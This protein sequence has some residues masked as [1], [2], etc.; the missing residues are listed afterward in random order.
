MKRVHSVLLAT[1][2]LLFCSSAFATNGMLM[3]GYGAI[4]HA[5]GGTSMA[6]DNGTGAMAN[7]PATLGLMP[8]GN[9]IDVSFG[10]MHPDV[11]F[12]TPTQD[13]DSDSNF[14]MM[15]AVG[16]VRR[17]GDWALGVGMF[18]QGGMGTDYLNPLNM[19]SQV[20]FGK[21]IVPAAYNLTDKFT[22]GATLEYVRAEMDLVMPLGGGYM[23]DFRD[24]SD[25]SGATA[26]EGISG[27]L[28][29]VYQFHERLRF[30]ASY[31][32]EGG[33]GDLTGRGAR[34][35]GLDLPAVA[36]AGFA[37]Q[38]TDKLMLTADYNRIFWSNSM[39]TITVTQ[40]GMKVPFVQ[41][42][43]D[44]NVF[45]FG[46]A[47]DILPELTLRLG[48]SFANNPIKENCTPL[49]PAILEDHYTAGFGYRF[50]EMHSVDAS[51]G[52][53]P[54]VEQS[55]GLGF[56]GTSTSHS[57]INYQVMYSLKF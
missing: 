47:Y 36:S 25:M 30:G 42:W 17:H 44:Q 16:Y 28:G 46:L 31:Q 35:K 23:L 27:K 19:Y 13:F 8:L 5:M 49:F 39:E 38:V 32:L 33:L 56:A 54:K 1:F 4:S 2:M 14:F 26:G 3:E 57:Q 43:D 34:V 10:F 41:D 22:I 6:F 51:L 55:N 7:N 24:G 40:N 20:I 11:T 52:Y 48:A 12:K 50:N 15:P 53:A 21:V 18:S 9:R 45:A 37:V 29:L